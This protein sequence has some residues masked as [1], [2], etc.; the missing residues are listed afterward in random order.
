MITIENKKDCSGCEA[1]KSVCPKS[2]IEMC[3][4]AE[5]F[6][7]PKVDKD[8]CI[9]CNL[10]SNICPVIHSADVNEFPQVYAAYNKN[11]KVRLSSSS[12][13][14]FYSLSKKVIEEKG[15]VFGAAFDVSF[16][17]KHIFIEDEKDIKKL[18]GSKYVQSRIGEAYIDAERFLKNGRKV[19]FSGTPCQIAGLYAYLRKPYDKLITVDII[20]HGVPSPKVWKEYLKLKEKKNTEIKNVCFR[21]KKF[22]WSNFS[23]KIS[24]DSNEIYES[25]AGKD[26]YMRG[27]LSNVYLRPSCHKCAFKGEQ[28][29]ADITLA[30]FWGIDNVMPDINQD[31][32]GISMVLVNSEKA[33]EY[34]KLDNEIQYYKVDAKA[35]LKE[36]SA[37]VVSVKENKN[38][39]AFFN[40][41]EKKGVK[42]ALKKYCRYK[43]SAVLYLKL[44][45]VV[46]NCLKKCKVIK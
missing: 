34:L 4:D 18:M 31:N 26:M 10:C 15:V 43:M 9:H 5:G 28:R 8:N 22:G 30:D 12:G 35:A 19:L 7:Y 44:K 23:F 1:C 46:Y 38:R 39:A 33:T 6:W 24:Y 25:V 45:V 36:N 32:K 11:E 14:I 3:F 42:Y 21:D 13:G 16:D 2:C 27:F 37:A 17:V 29:V 40:D 41:F 20:C